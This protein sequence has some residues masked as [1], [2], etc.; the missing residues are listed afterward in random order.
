MLAPLHADLD[1]KIETEY[2]LQPVTEFGCELSKAFK[3]CT[4]CQTYLVRGVSEENLRS[5]L[6]QHL[7]RYTNLFKKLQLHQLGMHE[8][9]F[10]TCLRIQ[11]KQVDLP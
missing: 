9:H 4:S 10:K 2:E 3:F 8:F 6:T 5:F 7:H 11:I 1:G